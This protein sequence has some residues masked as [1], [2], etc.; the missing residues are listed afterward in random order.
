MELYFTL[1]FHTIAERLLERANDQTCCVRR[2]LT[3]MNPDWAGL[4][5]TTYQHHN[6]SDLQ[7]RRVRPSPPHDADVVYT[8]R[9]LLLLLLL[10]LRRSPLTDT[11]NVPKIQQ[12]S[13][14]LCGSAGLKMHIYKPSYSFRRAILTGVT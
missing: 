7:H 10:L 12:A 9:L 4:S 5:T 2:M 14:E 1:R 3:L 11:N 13:H 8:C 6:D